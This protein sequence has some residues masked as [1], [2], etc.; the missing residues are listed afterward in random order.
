MKCEVQGQSVVAEIE[1][2]PAWRFRFRAE[3]VHMERQAAHAKVALGLNGTM[4]AWDKMNLESQEDRRAIVN[5][6]YKFV[7]SEA[8]AL[9]PDLDLRHNFDLFCH[10]VWPTWVAATEAVPMPG[11]PDVELEFLL[12]PYILRNGG[13]ILFAPPGRGKSYVG[14]L[15]AV[16]IDANLNTFWPVKQTSVLLVNLERSSL[17]VA[18][19]LGFIN[20]CLNLPAN[21]P[22]L[23]LNARGRRLPDIYD[24]LARCVE[25][26][27]VG[28]MVL[29]SISRTGMG[30]L[31][32][33]ETGNAIMDALSALC[34]TWLAIGHTPRADEGHIF[35]AVQFDCA[36]DI[37][38]QLLTEV[39]EDML[40]IGLQVT[41]DN[42][43]GQVPEQILRLKF[44]RPLPG[45]ASR[46]VSIEKANSHEFIEIEAQRK[47]PLATEV[48]DYLLSKGMATA[49][50]IADALGRPRSKISYLLNHDL[51]KRFVETKR[52][53]QQVFYGVAAK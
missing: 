11:N 28:L 6:A 5:Y 16:C 21:R 29:D 34:P 37:A 38:L 2:A 46:L 33:N 26:N 24:S 27:R 40:G 47:M 23:T 35:G 53:K 50:Q 8:K 4:L 14:L 43:I 45:L 1:F 49:T 12:Y 7:P 32:S 10:E 42:D 18:R 30:D 36:A 22:L 19:R 31:T 51:E 17:S 15:M 9:C 39:K 44:A 3:N 13:T 41:K 20:R 25:K 48:M 52:E